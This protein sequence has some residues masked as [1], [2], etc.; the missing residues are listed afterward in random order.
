MEVS[1]SPAFHSKLTG[2]RDVNHLILTCQEGERNHVA[3]RRDQRRE[4]DQHE[5][6][7]A[8]EGEAEQP[9]HGAHLH[10]RFLVPKPLRLSKNI[11][12]YTTINMMTKMSKPEAV[13]IGA[14]RRT[15]LG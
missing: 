6:Q 10:L 15:L 14:R 9:F 1:N 12:L 4:V 2:R 5:G 13:G 3:Q 11:L 7:R 8:E